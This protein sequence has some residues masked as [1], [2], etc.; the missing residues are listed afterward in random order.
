MKKIGLVSFFLLLMVLVSGVSAFAD[1]TKDCIKEA[2]RTYIAALKGLDRQ[3]SDFKDQ[4]IALLMVF[5]E[6]IALCESG[7]SAGE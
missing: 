2:R 6:D 1:D 5:K 3:A 7:T 4:K